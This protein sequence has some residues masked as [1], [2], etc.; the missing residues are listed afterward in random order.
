MMEEMI[1]LRFTEE[2]LTILQAI[3]SVG[4]SVRNGN[5]TTEEDS[6]ERICYM[7]FFMKKW[8]E[9]S[10]SLAN[11]MTASIKVCQELLEAK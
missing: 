10:T 11:K 1:Q 2:E 8:P 7:N 9:A 5:T 6:K 3:I 4:V